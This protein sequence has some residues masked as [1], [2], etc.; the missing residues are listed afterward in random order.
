MLPARLRPLGDTVRAVRFLVLLFG[1]AACARPHPAPANG[2]EATVIA[3]EAP[4]DA[5]VQDAAPAAVWTADDLDHTAVF[6]AEELDYARGSVAD[7]RK[8]GERGGSPE[9]VGF[10]HAVDDLLTDALTRQ[11]TRNQLME[12]YK[13]L[14]DGLT[15]PLDEATSYQLDDL[16]ELFRRARLPVN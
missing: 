14:E 4:R 16:R 1:L 5:P 13:L 11:L 9:L 3:G 2:T 6:D 7:L 12:R 15:D 8:K 10:A